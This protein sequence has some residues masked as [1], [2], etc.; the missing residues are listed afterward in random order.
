MSRRPQ[1][2][3]LTASIRR[4]DYLGIVWFIENHPWIA[5]KQE[6][7]KLQQ[8]A[9]DHMEAGESD[10][11]ET[12][13]HHALA[14]RRW[15]NR[16]LQE[17]RKYF[18][19]LAEGGETTREFNRDV[20][21]ALAALHQEHGQT[22]TGITQSQTPVSRENDGGLYYIDSQG[23]CVRPASNRHNPDPSRTLSDPAT[24]DRRRYTDSQGRS[25][26]PASNR[27]NPNP[28]RILSDPGTDDRRCYTD[29]QGRS[30]R[31][32]SNRHNTDPS[33]TLSD[34]ATDD[35]NI[36]EHGRTPVRYDPEPSIRH[37]QESP[38]ST[39]RCRPQG[40]PE[41]PLKSYFLP[42]EDINY[43]VIQRDITRHLGATANVKLI[44][45]YV[46]FRKR[47]R[48]RGQKRAHAFIG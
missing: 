22:A 5:D 6:I 24:D 9:S 41:P 47:G 14:L 18:E 37:R 17:A 44:E 28:S 39:S 3:G 43:D 45:H 26:R 7:D 11:A 8:Q 10:L 31:P 25:V 13:V 30:V 38:N 1:S 29:S 33:R 48:K 32:A 42:T 15:H 21:K 36:R 23:N 19:S 20:A 40:E 34:P 12:C 27:H 35:R 46:S 4:G 16:R 2:W